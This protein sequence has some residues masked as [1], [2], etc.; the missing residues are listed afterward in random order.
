MRAS[1]KTRRLTGLALMT[2][3]VVVLQVVASFVKFGPFLHI[4]NLRLFYKSGIKYRL[5]L[6]FFPE[7][8]RVFY[9]QC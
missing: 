6:S 5:L 7:D 3:I 8:A 1:E 9:I 2:A 4:R